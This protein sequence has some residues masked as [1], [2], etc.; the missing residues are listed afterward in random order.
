MIVGCLIVYNE[1]LMIS[2]A[3]ESLQPHCDR[4]IVIDGA[5]KNYP[6][7]NGDPESTDGTLEIAESMGADI[8]YHGLWNDQIEKRN[9]YIDLCQN[10]DFILHLDCDERLVAEHGL[11]FDTTRGAYRVAIHNPIHNTVEHWI[12]LFE[13]RAGVHYQGAH[14][15]LFD[16]D[17]LI[18]DSY[19]PVLDGVAIDHLNYM[20]PPGRK[21]RSSQYYALQYEQEREFRLMAGKP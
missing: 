8:W 1:S 4:I 15:L 6:L 17:R 9:E 14:N 12:R 11:R 21:S 7:I 5:Y 3:I 16:G 20:R 10:G 2:G 19:C 13:V 18:D